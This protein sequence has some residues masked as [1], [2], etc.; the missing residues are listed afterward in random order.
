M[1]T[2]DLL[3]DWLKPRLSVEALAWLEAKSAQITAGTSDNDVFSAFSAAVRHSGKMPLALSPD[4]LR[5]AAATVPGWNPG[6]WTCDEAVRAYLLLSLPATPKSAQLMDQLYETADLGETLAL[7]KALPLLA[8]P[9]AHMQR[10]REGL[11][12]NIKLAFEAVALRN[13]YPAL[14]FDELAWNHLVVRT[15]FVDSPLEEVEG[16]DKR[17]NPTLS[18]MLVDLVQERWAA[19]RTISPQIWRCVGP[20]ADDQALDALKR[21]YTEG[22]PAH[23]RAAAAALLSCPAKE[24]AAAI[25]NADPA[26]AE[27]VR[28]GKN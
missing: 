8:N 20:Y 4:Q 17:V 21:A 15:Q 1:T 6:G 5:T 13:P 27:A 16:L 9:E 2:K 28:G 25:L 24:K 22:D 14:H 3:L 19:G 26:L 10:A 12:S 23:Q 18:A 7:Q 11:R